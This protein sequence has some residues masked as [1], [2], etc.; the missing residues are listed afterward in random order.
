MTGSSGYLANVLS[1]SRAGR[2]IDAGN[3]LHTRGLLDHAHDRATH[4]ATDTTDDHI[5]IFGGH[6]IVTSS[7]ASPGECGVRLIGQ[8]GSV[9]KVV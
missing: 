4:P 8:L 2:F 7:R 3:Q 1:Q 9:L 5:K 6:E